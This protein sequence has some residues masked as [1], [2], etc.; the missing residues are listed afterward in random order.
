MEGQLGKGICQ[1]ILSGVW[2]LLLLSCGGEPPPMGEAVINRDSL[3]VMLTKGV[4]KLISDSGVIRY[5]IIAEE[6][7]VYDKT[8]PPRQFFPKGIY[9]ERYDKEF[10]VNLSITAD[11]AYCFDQNLWKMRGRVVVENYEDGTKF[12][13]DELYWDMAKHLLYSRRYFHIVTPDKDLEGNWFESDETLTKYHVK[14]TSGFLPMKENANDE[15]NTKADENPL[16]DS[17]P[18]RPAPIGSRRK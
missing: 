5:K 3:P 16:T 13:S 9:L 10:K 17:I 12:T 1:T 14:R 18:L 4:S 11:T 8:Q 2:L 6:W 7:E 15:T